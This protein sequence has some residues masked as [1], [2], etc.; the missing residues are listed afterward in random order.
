[1]VHGGLLFHDVPSAVVW[2]KSICPLWMVDGT[3]VWPFI[4]VASRGMVTCTHLACCQ[5]QVPQGTVLHYHSHCVQ[6][7]GPE[8]TI[9]KFGCR[10]SGPFN[11]PLKLL[12]FSYIDLSV[13]LRFKDFR[14][15]RKPR[16]PSL[17]DDM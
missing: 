9:V 1:M 6:K 11:I 2:A 10:S 12:E 14:G 15:R 7:P 5:G 3:V 13:H 8:H 16:Q 4:R 17:F